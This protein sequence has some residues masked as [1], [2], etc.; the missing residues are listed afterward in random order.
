MGARCEP[1]GASAGEVATLAG[2]G[3]GADGG[4]DGAG[5]EPPCAG[6]PGSGCV[7]M[8]TLAGI[9]GRIDGIGDEAVGPAG[10]GCTG[11]ALG[12]DA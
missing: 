5:S 3:G 7:A 10:A 12:G 4:V 6:S 1:P 9:A 11:T 8:R 2:S